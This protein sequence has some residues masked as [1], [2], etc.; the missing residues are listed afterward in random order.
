MNLSSCRRPFWLPFWSLVHKSGPRGPGPHPK[1][2]T[3]H[4]HG[5]RGYP[6]GTQGC[7]NKAPSSPQSG[8]KT[9]N[10]TP[11]VSKWKAKVP[12]WSPKAKETPQGPAKCHKDTHRSQQAQL[13]TNALG[14][15]PGHKKTPTNRPRPDARR[16]RRRSAAPRQEVAGCARHVIRIL[17]K[18]GGEASP[19]APPLPPTFYLNPPRLLFLTLFLLKASLKFELGN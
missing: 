6:N 12:Q 15:A 2:P 8:Q 4:Q 18:L 13:D 3:G 5:P 11:R 1:V 14:K 17:S 7:R 10:Y 16:R 9:P 19:L